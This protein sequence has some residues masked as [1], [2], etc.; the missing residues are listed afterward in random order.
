MQQVLLNSF[1]QEQE[2][3]IL[4]MRVKLSGSVFPGD[5]ANPYS[6]INCSKLAL[7]AQLVGAGRLYRQGYEFES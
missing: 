5:D 6:F 3:I 4:V 7:V 2:P 1:I